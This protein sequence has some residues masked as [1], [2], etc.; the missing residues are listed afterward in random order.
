M[1]SILYVI[2]LSFFVIQNVVAHVNGPKWCKS[3][4]LTSVETMICGDKALQGADTLMSHIYKQV[5]TFKGKEGHEGMWYREVFSNQQDWIK[6]R[7][8]SK[9]KAQVLDAYMT[10]NQEL[11][12]ILL[13]RRSIKY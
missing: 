2:L 13:D 9:S 1:K 10:R 8:R 5:M 3:T 12:R 4:G 7:N 11:Y 6:A